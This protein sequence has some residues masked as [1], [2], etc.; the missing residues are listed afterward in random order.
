ML[1][2]VVVCAH[3]KSHTKKTQ[4]INLHILKKACNFAI[5]ILK[6]IFLP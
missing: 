1:I 6:T 4:L 2:F 3:S 5:V